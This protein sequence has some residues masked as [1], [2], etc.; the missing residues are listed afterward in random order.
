MRLNTLPNT[1]KTHEGAT[2]KHI[3]SED[4]LRR[5]VMSCLL[6]E[7]EFYEDE[8]TIANRIEA[9]CNEVSPGMIAPLAHDVRRDHNLRHVSLL[10]CVCAAKR[11]ALSANDLARVIQRPDEIMEFLSI[12]WKDGKRPLSAQ[13]KKGLS[14]AF[15]KFN[16]Y[17]F[18]KY[19][20]NTAIKLRD[21]LFLCHANPDTF[22]KEV[23]FKKIVDNTL[24]TPDTWEVA[25]SDGEDKRESWIR[26]MTDGKLGSLALLR[27]L[28]NMISV[29]VPRD[30]IE[31]ALRT[32]NTRRILPF[33]F[34]SAAKHAPMFEPHLESALFRSLEGDY[35]LMGRTVLLVDVSRSMTSNI[36][37]R[38][39]I[40]RMDASIGLA[41]ILREL[42]ENI[43]VY[44]FSEHLSL[45]PSH[46]GFGLA[47]AIDK[48]Q[49]HW[50]TYLG[51]ALLEI[52]TKY[53]TCDRLIVI[54]DEQSYDRISDP[55]SAYQK[56]Y[57]I[58]VASAKNGV[59]Y[60]TWT[61]I[62]GFSESVIKWL[63]EYER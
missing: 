57:M 4:M 11:K 36:S 49:G 56:N 43:D 38:S 24:A 20:R 13:I 53:I 40:T 10:L 12:Y 26:L 5:S 34:I 19:N 37:G 28:R 51:K 39:E 47:T 21:V 16:E 22:E 3:S 27:N 62:D 6:W 25:L 46:R 30:I 48:S 45:V 8:I 61:H 44:S 14:I 1:L 55:P 52:Y 7:K 2:A 59:G 54:T 23:L 18:A 33:R 42:C 35:K 58:N 15:N 41:M 17:Q 32:M 9:L 63:V 29:D 60:H 50:S 31:H